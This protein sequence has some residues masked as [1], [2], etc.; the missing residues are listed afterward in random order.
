MRKG[1]AMILK[2]EQDLVCDD[3]DISIKY[4]NMNNDVQ[5]IITFLKSFDTQIKCDDNG[6]ERIIKASE[7]FYIESVDKKTFLYLEKSVCRTDLR[8]YQLAD[9][10]AH[11]GF[12]QV[13]KSCILNINTLESIKPL[14][15]SRMEATLR[16]GERVHINR[17]YL[18]GVKK[19]LR[20]AI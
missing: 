8:L 18:S 14:I 17:N 2:I 11:L 16:N 13:T 9:D 1:G 3:I 15:N 4:S 6:T 10:L 7:I 19:A 5:R 20:G 12:V